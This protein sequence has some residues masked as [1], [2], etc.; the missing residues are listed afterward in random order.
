MSNT[1]LRH[2]D[3]LSSSRALAAR[4]AF[5]DFHRSRSMSRTRRG[6]GPTAPCRRSGVGLLAD[7]SKRRNRSRLAGGV[8]LALGLPRPSN[9]NHGLDAA[10]VIEK[11]VPRAARLRSNSHRSKQRSHLGNPP[12]GRRAHLG[13]AENPSM[14]IDPARVPCA[15]QRLLMSRPGLVSASTF[16]LPS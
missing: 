5:L 1:C 12:A 4:R 15:N 14:M 8:I 10:Q 2:D 3:A 11:Q 9:A 7:S 6:C 16:A 13:R